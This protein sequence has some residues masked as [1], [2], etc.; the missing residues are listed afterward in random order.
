LIKPHEIR[1]DVEGDLDDEDFRLLREA[2]IISDSTQKKTSE[3]KPKH[4]VFVDGDEE[5][6][7]FS[8]HTYRLTNPRQSPV[9]KYLSL[10]DH[11]LIEEVDNTMA[12][13]RDLGWKTIEKRK[14]STRHVAHTDAVVDEND[15]N[16]K[17]GD[18]RRLL[19]ELAAR[20]ARD[21]Q[22]RYA[23]RELEMQRLM[24]GKGG[25]RKLRGAEKIEGGS[26]DEDE[27]EIDARKGKMRVQKSKVDEETY[28]P[29]V[30]KWRLERKR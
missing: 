19:T 5:G 24:M 10:N 20:L 3:R 16:V 22:L 8:V 23:E 15:G 26:E 17:L 1:D 30:Y 29:R 6:M 13:E 9:Q 27:D 4:I 21:K 18:R 28:K 14:K 7:L 12:V 2:G 25:R 11:S